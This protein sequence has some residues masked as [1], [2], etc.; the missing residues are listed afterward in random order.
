MR[1][2]YLGDGVYVAHDDFG[3]VLTTE[4]GISI[5]NRI[6]LE[7]DV[8]SALVAYVAALPSDPPGRD[9]TP[10]P[11]HPPDETCPRCEPSV[12]DPEQR[13]LDSIPEADDA[14]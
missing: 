4:D 2:A 7:P 3:L 14:D 1:K 5:L 6:V 13:A 9:I 11:S 12:T 10:L 8:Y